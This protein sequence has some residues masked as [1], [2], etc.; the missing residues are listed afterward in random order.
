MQELDERAHED[1]YRVCK[2]ISN[3]IININCADLLVLL[4]RNKCKVCGKGFACES[5]PSRGL[6]E[7]GGAHAGAHGG[8]AIPQN[9]VA[10]L[11]LPCTTAS[12]MQQ[13]VQPQE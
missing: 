1:T 2:N 6:I 5:A 8:K 12:R 3:G 13:A 9:S 11:H 4:S 7:V 10:C